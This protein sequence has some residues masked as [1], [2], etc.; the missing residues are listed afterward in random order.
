MT[1]FCNAAIAMRVVIVMSDIVDRALKTYELARELD[2]SQLAYSRY[3][4]ERYID[5]LMA[6]GQVDPQRLTEFAVPYFKELHDGPDIRF[7]GC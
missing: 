6:A 5:K 4:I 1:G 3:S 2:F 7:T